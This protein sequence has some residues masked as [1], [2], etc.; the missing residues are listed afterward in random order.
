MGNK[1]LCIKAMVAA[2]V[3]WEHVWLR[4]ATLTGKQYFC[5]ELSGVGAVPLGIA[6]SY[7][8]RCPKIKSVAY[9]MG[10]DQ[11]SYQPK[12]SKFWS[13]FCKSHC[14]SYRM[15][16]PPIHVCSITVNMF[17]T[18]SKS[19]CPLVGHSQLQMCPTEPFRFCLPRGIGN[20]V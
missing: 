17:H 12:W 15:F 19:L 13:C 18:I 11:Y 9:S 8:E 1:I 16:L 4:A 7:D 6:H 2:T 3:L 20:H 10:I 5:I 14:A